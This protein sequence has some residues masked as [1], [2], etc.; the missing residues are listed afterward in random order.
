MSETKRKIHI[1]GGLFTTSGYSSAGRKFARALHAMDNVDLTIR[2]IPIQGDIPITW[3]DPLKHIQ[4]HPSPDVDV[5]LMWGV[6]DLRGMYLDRL[7]IPQGVSRQ[8]MV[9]WELDEIPKI[10]ETY[11]DDTNWIL[12]PSEFS[13]NSMK[14]LEGK[15]AVIPHGYDAN[16]YFPKVKEVKHGEPFK[17]LFFGTWIKRKAPLE[18]LLSLMMGLIDRDAVIYIK[19]NYDLNNLQNIKNTIESQMMKTE[20]IDADRLPKVVILNGTY[21]EEELNDLY[22]EVDVTVLCSRGEAWGLPLMHS[23]ATNTP[24]ITTNQGGQMDYIPSD[25]PYLVP[26]IGTEIA[27]GDGYMSQQMGLRWHSVDFNV[28]QTH[29]RAMYDK[30]DELPKLGQQL[31]DYQVKNYTWENVAKIYLSLLDILDDNED[32][33][34]ESEDGLGETDT[35]ETTS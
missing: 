14:R 17:V 24:V 20:V 29:I 18:T 31:F 10:W 16:T 12:T 19:V 33:L 26:I 30:R 25:Y 7:P 2:D 4:A 6:P 8:H 27:T 15:V 1:D 23:I 28:I 32:K 11:L 21:T 35:T 13:R 34:I 5:V 3:D 22:N 9:S